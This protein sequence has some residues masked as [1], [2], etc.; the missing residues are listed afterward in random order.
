MVG[1]VLKLDTGIILVALIPVA[2]Q[3]KINCMDFGRWKAALHPFCQIVGLG[4][5]YSA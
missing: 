3:V 4:D 5:F 2:A 1:V